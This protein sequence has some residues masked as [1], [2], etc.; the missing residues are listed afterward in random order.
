MSKTKFLDLDGVQHLYSKINENVKEKFETLNETIVN[1]PA[2]N[3]FS[4]PKQYE[5]HI[6]QNQVEVDGEIKEIHNDIYITIKNG[7]MTVYG[8]LDYPIIYNINFNEDS[9][10]LPAGTYTFSLQNLSTT[11]R[12][13]GATLYLKDEKAAFIQDASTGTRA[14]L[15]AVPN[16][17]YTK[18]TF[19]ILEQKTIKYMSIYLAPQGTDTLTSFNQSFSLQIENG[20]VA[21]QY[22]PAN[23]KAFY[24]NIADT[25]EDLV[26]NVVY[27]SAFGA[28]GDGITDDTEALQN[29]IDYC[30]ETYKMLK[31]DSGKNYLISSPLVW[32]QNSIYLDGNFST[33]SGWSFRDSASQDGEVPSHLISLNCTNINGADDFHTWNLK[34]LRQQV[35]KNI[36]LNC[37]CGIESGIYIYKGVKTHCSNITI[38][39]PV[40]YGIFVS[41]GYENYISNIHITRKINETNEKIPNTKLGGTGIYVAGSD[42]SIDNVVIVGC[43]YG[44]VN[45]GSDN[46]YTK[47]HPWTTIEALDNLKESISFDCRWGYCTFS[48]CMGDSTKIIF[49]LSANSKALISG[50]VNTWADGFVEATTTKDSDLNVEPKMSIKPYLFYFQDEDIYRLDANGN[51]I[52]DEENEGQYLKFIAKHENK[53]ADVTISSCYFKPKNLDNYSN[54]KCHYSN[55]LETDAPMLIDRASDGWF[56]ENGNN[57]TISTLENQKADKA[58]VDNLFLQYENDILSILGGDEE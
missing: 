14:T 53:G 34:D 4:L 50:C 54:F 33:I 18:K 57:T 6:K 58:Y 10:D 3:I 30:S 2:R 11:S 35:I 52:P 45:S 48:Q 39:N 28:V 38:K 24:N 40:K 42:N 1:P 46:H 44:I 56:D 25:V 32:S 12:S 20:D 41:Q 37:N 47:V 36:T 19:T 16:A 15:T 43:Q 26:D 5:Y 17:A 29:A 23:Q 31:L 22:I 8:K 7:V 49:R 51:P 27:A 55:L 9:F 21:T 13:R